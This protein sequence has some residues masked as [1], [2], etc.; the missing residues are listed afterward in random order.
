MVAFLG[1]FLALKQ[2][3][4]PAAIVVVCTTRFALLR[5][6]GVQGLFYFRNLVVLITDKRKQVAD[7]VSD[8]VKIAK[9]V[10][11]ISSLLFVGRLAVLI[12]VF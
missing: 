6:Q 4:K 9:N 8:H 12:D 2:K 5:A 10:D 1:K 3:M 7:K 11:L